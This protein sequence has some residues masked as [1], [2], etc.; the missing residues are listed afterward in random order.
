MKAEENRI[1]NLKVCQEGPPV[2]SV[3]SDI[4]AGNVLIIGQIPCTA[5]PKISHQFSNA[6][7][8]EAKLENIDPVSVVWKNT[9]YSQQRHTGENNKWLLSIASAIDLMTFVL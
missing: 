3:W 6:R 2:F 9:I 7:E 8:E 4:S 5:P 1:E